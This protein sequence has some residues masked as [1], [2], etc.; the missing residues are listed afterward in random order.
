[1]SLPL[2]NSL[3]QGGQNLFG[4]KTQLQFGKLGVT[5]VAATVRGTADE[6]RVRNGAQSRH[7]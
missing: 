2:T 7:V 5:A 3:V 6:V 4:I 1:M